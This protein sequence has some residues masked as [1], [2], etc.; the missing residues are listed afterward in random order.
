MPPPAGQPLVI[1]TGVNVLQG[2][3]GGNFEGAT[4]YAGSGIEVLG[5]ALDG[6]PPNFST[7]IANLIANPSSSVADTIATIRSQVAALVGK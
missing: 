5:N 3:A 2:W 4:P 1:P 6:Y 7:L